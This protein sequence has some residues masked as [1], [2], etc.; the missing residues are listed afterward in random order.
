LPCGTV[1]A[2][3]WDVGLSGFSIKDP[4]PQAGRLRAVIKQKMD[5][6]TFMFQVL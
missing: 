3:D 5:F 2:V 4:A 6:M 1:V